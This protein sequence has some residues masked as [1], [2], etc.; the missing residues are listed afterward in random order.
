MQKVALIT[1]HGMGKYKPTYY[2]DLQEKLIKEF[3]EFWS[4]ISFSPVQYQVALQENQNDLWNK[5]MAESNNELDFSKIRKFMLYGFGD[6]GSLAHSSGQD[7]TTYKE[8]QQ[9]IY[10]ALEKAYADVGPDCSVV[11]LA[12]S[13][14]CQVISNYIWDAEH[15]KNLFADYDEPDHGK[16][17]FMRLRTLEN[18]VT[19]GCNIPMFNSGMSHRE[20][21]KPPNPNFRWD[22]YYDADDVLGWPLRQLGSTYHQLVTDHEVNAGTIL[23]SWTPFSHSEYWTDKDVF[24]PL[25]TI[26]QSKLHNY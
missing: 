18:L 24:R 15:R 13:L 17:K 19:T 3:G 14:G 16:S 26:L 21:F 20:C 4:Q 1:L 9:A 12:Q 10:S 23:S 6:A 7:S 22:N 5:M 2:F 8:V 11:I 25:V